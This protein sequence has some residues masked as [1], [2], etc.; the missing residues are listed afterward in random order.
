M[1]PGYI[2]AQMTGALL[3]ALVVVIAYWQHYVV[4]DDPDTVRATF[5]TSPAIRHPGWNFV[6]ETIGT[7]VL[8]FA[9][10]SLS[11]PRLGNGMQ[12]TPIGLGSLGALP[13]GLLVFA[14]GMSL[15]GPTGYA[16]NPARDLAPRILHALLPLPH[17]GQSDWGYAAIPVFGPIAGGIAAAL[18]AR[19]L[20]L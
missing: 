16:I 10:L 12:S 13:V 6:T 2:A 14:I 4:T 11:D 19:V 15:G 5:C 20:L 18:V 17:K 9:V 8:V 3:G 1:A 7:F